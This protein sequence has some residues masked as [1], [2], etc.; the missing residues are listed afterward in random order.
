MASLSACW[1]QHRPALLV[2]LPSTAAQCGTWND[3]GLG[4]VPEAFLGARTHRHLESGRPSS[5]TLPTGRQCPFSLTSLP[6][7]S[8]KQSHMGVDV[9]EKGGST[10]SSPESCLGY[11]RPRGLRVRAGFGT[12]CVCV[13][14]LSLPPHI[15]L[16]RHMGLKVLDCTRHQRRE[17]SVPSLSPFL[18]LSSTY[19]SP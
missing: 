12:V 13:N 17:K 7:A 11:A 1:W 10:L 16:H 18:T 9:G 2:L 15:H 4:G 8:A 6:P 3:L 19:G 14:P 5:S